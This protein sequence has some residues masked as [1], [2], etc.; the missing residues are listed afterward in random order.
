[1]GHLNP[2]W[3]Y[4]NSL[5][6]M[7][8]LPESD[9]SYWIKSRNV[10]EFIQSLE[11]KYNTESFGIIELDKPGTYILDGNTSFVRTKKGKG[12]G[13]WVHLYLML[14]AAAWLDS[15]FELQVYESFVTNKILQ[16]RDITRK[17]TFRLP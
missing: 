11:K 6:A 17:S 4:G 5:R 14:K 3:D 7:K 13:T 12:G 15:D 10:V 8:G 2:L 16:W 1:M 9:M